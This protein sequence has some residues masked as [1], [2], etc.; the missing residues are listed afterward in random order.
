MS[1]IVCL[2]G[3]GIVL[4]VMHNGFTKQNYDSMFNAQKTIVDIICDDLDEDILLWG[5]YT[6]TKDLYE[7]SLVSDAQA[8]DAQAHT[9]GV[10][11]D[12][13]LKQLSRRVAEIGVPDDEQ[14]IYDPTSNPRFA[15]IVYS[16]KSGTYE[17]DSEFGKIAMYFRWVPTDLGDYLIVAGISENV[18]ADAPL[19]LLLLYDLLLLWA[20]A[21]PILDIAAERKGA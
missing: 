21:V 1:L 5:D 9:V 7:Q 18:I 6:D 14:Y 15:S 12:G 16:A 17:T 19:W 20:V 4:N 2:V 11:Y 8:I 10:L 13:A 3:L